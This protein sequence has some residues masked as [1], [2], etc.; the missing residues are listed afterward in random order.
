MDP[1]S[2]EG[3]PRFEVL[4]RSSEG[5]ARVG[6]LHT[7]HG[8]LDT[9][10]FFPVG[11]Y[12]AVRGLTPEELREV[13]VQGILANTYHLHLRPGEDVIERLGGLHPFMGW[14][15]PIL[16][17]SGGF[18]LYSLDHLCRRS[19]EG[20][21]FKSPID[22]SE[23]F[24][25]PER[26]IEIQ[27]ALGADLIVTL[28]EFEPV[29]ADPG[30]ADASRVRALL[31]R[32]LRWAQRGQAAQRRSDQLLFGIVQ[33]GG[34]EALRAESAERTRA[35][36]FRAFAIGG[37]GLG[38][39]AAQRAAL[40]EAALA[41]LPRRE[42]RYLMGLGAPHDLIE[43][44]ARGVDLFDCVLPTR[45]GRHG[46]VFTHTGSLNLRNARFR[47]DSEPLDLEC[48]CSVCARYSRAY[49]RHLIV[50]GEML[51]PRLLTLHNLAFYMRLLERA[52]EAIAEDRF[53]GWC[54]EWRRSYVREE[55][56]GE[57]SGGSSA[58]THSA[59]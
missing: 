57:R 15:G 51:G 38:E 26:C 43:A 41:P 52:R 30:A 59:A 17:D 39:A 35:L 16:T 29:P 9:P 32:T 33:G 36:G 24:L 4:A 44:V 6:R 25:S 23:R 34:M 13:G 48:S 18:Q 56:D 10:A 7:P 11:T 14:S 45:H 28:D 8:N 58:A 42:P 47:E 54:A 19:E 20:V 22:G 46:S 21:H 1:L 55:P 31:E 53:E 27:E 49:L 3:A 50:S 12:A 2:S 5:S 37:L 40:L